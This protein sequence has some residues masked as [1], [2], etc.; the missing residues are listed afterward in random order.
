MRLYEATYK[1]PL[2]GNCIIEVRRADNFIGALY[3]LP[4]NIYPNGKHHRRIGSPRT[5]KQESIQ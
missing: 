1:D 3:E 2:T 5:H 4:R